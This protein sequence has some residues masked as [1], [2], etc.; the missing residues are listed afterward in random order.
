MSDLSIQPASR[1]VRPWTLL[2]VGLALMLAAVTAPSV[3]AGG[4]TTTDP[5]VAAAGWIAQQVETDATLGVGSLADAILAFAATGVGQAAAA[6]ALAR[7]EA[8]LEAFVS[9][10]VNLRPGALGKA[11]LAVSVQG[12]NVNSFGGRDLEADLRGLLVTSGPDTGRFG[13]ASVFDQTMAVLGL[14][15]TSGGVPA[16]AGDW[17]AAAQC[18]SGEYQWDGSCPAGA[19]LEDPDT[20]ALALQALLAAGE[21]AAAA[22]STAWLLGLQ[23]SDGS[24]ASF[25]TPNT[26]STGVAGQALRA[27]GETAAADAAAAFVVSLQLGCDA[28]PG[29]VGAIAWSAADPGFLIFSTPQAVLALGAPAL[30]T[31]TAAGSSVDAPVLE[32]ASTGPPAPASPTGSP[33]AGALPDTASGAGDA[34]GLLA[35]LA[36][37]TLVAAGVVV[38]RRKVG[39]RS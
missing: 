26:N 19:G 12:G 16:S 23:A 14:A 28:D 35:M 34:A 13:S 9:D 4:S 37:T 38:I 7:I 32:C 8:G 20:T 17:L 36:G 15:R 22:G 25:G 2:L 21:T 11:I 10:G 5:G 29:A 39:A 31:L 24:V 1:I 3:R 33:A 6:D 30:D 27:A 18:P